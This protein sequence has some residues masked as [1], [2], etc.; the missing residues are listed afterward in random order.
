MRSEILKEGFLRKQGYSLHIK[1]FNTSTD[2]EKIGNP[3]PNAKSFFIGDPIGGIG[4]IVEL[5]DG[6]NE[7]F[8]GNLPIELGKLSKYFP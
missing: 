6:T 7:K 4:W 5:P 1:N 3:P 8:Y 2:M